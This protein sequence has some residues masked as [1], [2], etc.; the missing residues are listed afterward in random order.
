[1]TVTEAIE[2]RRSIRAF[3]PAPVDRAVLDRVLATAQ[4]SPSGGNLQPWQATILTGA[5][6]DALKAAVAAVVASGPA[7]QSPEYPIYPANLANP[8]DARRRGVGEALYAAL[9]IERDNRIGRMVQM[10]ANFTGFGAPVMLFLHC[11][12]TMGPPQWGDM[13]IWLQTVMLLLAEAGL[14]SCPQEAWSLYGAEVRAATGLSDNQILWT[15]LAIGHPD[16]DAPVNQWP[17]PR[18]PMDEVVRWVEDAA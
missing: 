16:R 17:V 1:M 2:R 9:H 13:G 10:A 8:W 7:G 4:R 5:A 3:T 12:R 15:G 6:W 11:D 18:A 14:G